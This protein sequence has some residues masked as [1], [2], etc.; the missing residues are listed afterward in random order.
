MSVVT[1][2]PATSIVDVNVYLSRYPFRR[3]PLDETEKLVAKLRALKVTQ[4]WVGSF[5]ALL[6]KDIEGVNRR[7][8]EECA[9]HPELLAPMGAVNPMLPDWEEDLRRCAEEQKFRGIRLHPNYHGYKLDEPVFVEL[10]KQ[11]AG[12]KL[13]VQIVDHVED[14][15][16]QHRL[17]Q[18]AAVDWKPLAK[19]MEGMAE[20][21]V[22]LLNALRVARGEPLQSLTKT[23]NVFL[24][25]ACLEQV[26]GIKNVLDRFPAERLLFGSY[27]PFF[28]PESAVQKLTESGVS[29]EV[30]EEICHVNAGGLLRG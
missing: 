6:H 4:A 23:A 9:R 3:L 27:A 11:A 22:V 13:V 2:A 20:V 28:Y 15:R 12:R 10:L 25:I 18:V 5:D 24:E 19:V 26:G 1:T 14:E 8:A 29:G 17:M 30:L 16:T 7:L 21:K